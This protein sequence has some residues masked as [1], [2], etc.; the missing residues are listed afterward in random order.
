MEYSHLDL[1]D[2]R[3]V[4]VAYLK[5]G[6]I[7]EQTMIEKIGGELQA[8]ALE[9]A[10]VRKLLLN[11]QSVQFMSSA[12]LGKLVLLHKRCKADKIKLKFCGISK[13]VMEVFEITRL[14][15]IFDIAKDEDSALQA[16][17]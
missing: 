6:S 7:L 10:G 2:R 14:T 15:K 16:F 13:S 5:T 8:A 1:K 17:G 4:V 9:A 12:M 3:D 11:F